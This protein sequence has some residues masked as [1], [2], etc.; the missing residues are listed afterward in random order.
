MAP[1]S[2]SCSRGPTDCSSSSDGA[3]EDAIMTSSGG[4]HSRRGGV[5][6][7]WSC[8]RRCGAATP[9]TRSVQL[10]RRDRRRTPVSRWCSTMP[11]RWPVSGRRSR[12]KRRWRAAPRSWSPSAADLADTCPPDPETL[13]VA[14]R[15]FF[16]RAHHGVVRPGPHRLRCRLLAF[17]WPQAPGRVR[18]HDQRRFDPR[19]E[20][21]DR[22]RW[23]VLLPAEGRMWITEYPAAAFEKA[24]SVL[25]AV[26]DGRSR[27]R[28]HRA[29][30]EVPAPGLP[31]P[32]VQDL[33][34]VRV[35]LPR[36]AV[37][38]GR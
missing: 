28:R 17:L 11:S 16:N 3:N 24:R 34:V 14:R 30:P 19:H 36:L 21:R 8:S 12:P 10:S 25:P 23:R 13:G 6:G 4:R 32:G 22:V 33:T 5:G 27:G 20:G 26:E 31:G 38:P 15:Q 18:F 29:L 35:P 2:T 1:A 7:R 9:A 37:Q